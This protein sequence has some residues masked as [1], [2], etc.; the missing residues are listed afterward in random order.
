MSFEAGVPEYGAAQA[1]SGA[2]ATPC[3]TATWYAHRQAGRFLKPQQP[4]L[5]VWLHSRL[6]GALPAVS[7]QCPRICGLLGKYVCGFSGRTACVS[8]C[9]EMQVSFWRA[10]GGFFTAKSCGGM[11]EWIVLYLLAQ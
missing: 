2:Q 1:A 9:A 10:V 11:K 3:G 7:G 6:C 8:D 5:S 4:V